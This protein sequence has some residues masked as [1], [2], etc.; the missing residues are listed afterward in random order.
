LLLAMLVAAAAAGQQPTPSPRPT[1][2]VFKAEAR[3]IRVDAIVT[4]GKGHQVPD[5][6]AA[7]FEFEWGGQKR[8]VSFCTYIPVIDTP[9]APLVGGAKPTAAEVGRVL[10]FV[11]ANPVI[12]FPGPANAELVM[13]RRIRA[14]DMLQ[15]SIEHQ[16]GPHDIVG[17]F[18]ME[19]H[20]RLLG[21]FTADK[22]AMR[23]ALEEL[24]KGAFDTP[25]VV[26][27]PGYTSAWVHYNVEV[28]E[29]AGRVTERLGQLPGRKLL[30]F[31][32]GVLRIDSARS[33][34]LNAGDF[35]MVRDQIQRLV[36][37]ANHYG[38]TI[39]GVSLNGMTRGMSDALG[40][41]ADGT[42]G[43]TIENT[44]DLGGNLG[45]VLDQNAG[46][47]LLGYEPKAAERVPTKLKVRLL[48]PGL[49]IAARPRPLDDRP[50]PGRD[51]YNAARASEVLNSPVSPGGLAVQLRP[52]LRWTERKQ[53]EL[54]LIVDVGTKGFD[55]TPEAD[56]RPQV[57]FDLTTRV[58]NENG[59]SLHLE[60][61][62]TGLRFLGAVPDELS[63]SVKVPLPAPGLYQ[64]DAVVT[65]LRNQ[66]AGNAAEL[67]ELMSLSGNKLLAS[68][69]VLHARGDNTPKQSFA[70]G[71]EIQLGCQVAHARRAHPVD[72]AR[73]QLRAVVQ[74]D[75]VPVL[76]GEPVVF[77]R[78]QMGD[79]FDL[80]LPLKLGLA[81]GEYTVELRISD[82]VAGKASVTVVSPLRVLD[83]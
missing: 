45:R 71:A 38:V 16:V 5:L 49:T 52:Y 69:L 17:I 70:K 55:L 41:L 31:V 60:Q 3:V 57:Q 6:T 65:D 20:R 7:D 8:P 62:P 66:H 68:T 74:K 30:F 83:R 56:G 34:A 28:L 76:E 78:K 24:R 51:A 23:A 42:G 22:T 11:V 72:P 14:V 13:R 35:S 33:V 21:Q 10:A 61:K 47:Y 77:E 27:M 19:G 25:P 18:N 53:G 29:A 73:L 82:L 59:A 75:G 15:D 32:S 12:D 58:V 54:L 37:D 44:E 79:P 2:P 40:M 26:V 80:D 63:F 46:Y 50:Q 1:P 43:S 64:S 48:K 39:Y 36:G 67:V 9:R 4:D 81:P